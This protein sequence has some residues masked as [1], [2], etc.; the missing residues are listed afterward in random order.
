M[1]KKRILKI[2]LL[3]I[4]L[5]SLSCEKNNHYVAL[6]APAAFTPNIPVDVDPALQKALKEAGDIYQL[7]TGL[8]ISDGHG[9]FSI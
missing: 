3:S 6:E 7:N 5:F 2:A 4:V 8:K 9:F 1:F